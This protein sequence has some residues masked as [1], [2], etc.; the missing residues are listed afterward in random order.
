[1]R[2]PERLNAL[3][4]LRCLAAINIVFFHFSNPQWFGFLAPVVNAGYIS[5]S[6][7]ILLSGFV[8][9]YNY[10]GRARAGRWTACASGRRASR[11]FIPSTC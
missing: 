7:F 5:V 2:K 4:G 9:G 10:A 1:M 11:A 3:T 6:F 8:L